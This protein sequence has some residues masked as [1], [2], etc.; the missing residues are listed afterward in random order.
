M[1]TIGEH[2]WIASYVDVL[3]GVNIPDG[4]VIAYRSCV[5]KAFNEKG[6]LIAGYPAKVIRDNIEWK[7]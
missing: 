4:S 7:R 3:K 2:V 5:T 6:S 1:C